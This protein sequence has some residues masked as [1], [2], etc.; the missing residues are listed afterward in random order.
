MIKQ[1]LLIFYMAIIAV[2]ASG[3][4]VGFEATPLTLK[5]FENTGVLTQRSFVWTERWHVF[6]NGGTVD[7]Q[8]LSFSSMGVLNQDDAKE[9]SN[10]IQAVIAGLVNQIT[11]KG[12]LLSR[13]SNFRAAA[14]ASN[15]V[16]TEF[17]AIEARIGAIPD[18]DVD[19]I[20]FYDSL[21]RDLCVLGE[22]QYEQECLTDRKKELEE[23][24]KAQCEWIKRNTKRSSL[25]DKMKQTIRL[26]SAKE[27]IQIY[28]NRTR[29]LMEVKTKEVH[30]SAVRDYSEIPEQSYVVKELVL[31]AANEYFKH[32]SK[33]IATIFENA[34]IYDDIYAKRKMMVYIDNGPKKLASSKLFKYSPDT[35]VMQVQFTLMT[36]L[37]D[38]IRLLNTYSKAL[39]GP[40]GEV[41]VVEPGYE[42]PQVLI[43]F[44]RLLAMGK[45]SADLINLNPKFV[46]LW[47]N[48]F[49]SIIALFHQSFYEAL[50]IYVSFIKI[51]KAESFLYL[52]VSYGLTLFNLANDT[53]MQIEQAKSLKNGPEELLVFLSKVPFSE[54]FDSLDKT[55]QDI[56]VKAIELLCDVRLDEDGF[57]SPTNKT[58]SICTTFKLVYYSEVIDY[59][60]GLP[61]P[62]ADLDFIEW[63][64]SIVLPGNRV[65]RQCKRSYPPEELFLLM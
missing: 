42:Q 2:Y 17:R 64:K 24:V 1:T 27:F 23:R 60:I 10:E 39:G 51:E 57:N 11:L 62:D 65:K 13:M 43:D 22:Y 41:K 46:D 59:K 53:S 5:L 40:L 6:S 30:L 25:T 54:I 28:L 20:N 26:E 45:R 48:K 55:M 33:L 18:E 36:P 35:I 50:D 47:V 61:L 56:F 34:N 29:R 14:N 37:E 15:I 4:L 21:F 12:D 9:A 52:V 44:A 63:I 8:T 32:D 58:G 19:N 16:W 49:N 3:C 31:E 38:F 7:A